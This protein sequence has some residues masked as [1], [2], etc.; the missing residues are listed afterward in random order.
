MMGVRIAQLL[1]DSPD[2]R[3]HEKSRSMQIAIPKIREGAL[4]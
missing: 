3:R 4:C 2:D 1:E